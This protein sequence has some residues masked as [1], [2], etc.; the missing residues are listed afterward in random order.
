MKLSEIIHDDL[1]VVSLQGTDNTSVL[2]EFSNAICEAGKFDD[3]EVLFDRLFER[4][5][6]ES[7]GV[8]NG[9]AI[10][11]CKIENLK[12]VVLAVGYS[13]DGVDFKAC[14]SKPVYFFFLV[15]SP[16][17]ASVLHL[18]MLAA[19]SR[20]LRSS[21]FISQLQQEHPGKEDL[22]ALIKEEE[23]KAALAS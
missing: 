1:I 4:E 10:P 8:G 15:I 6:Q 18:R 11:H 13:S 3:R 22:I 23:E 2:R 9:I 5:R 19:L 7:T 12:Q 14:D 20:L 16:S 17:G 21:S